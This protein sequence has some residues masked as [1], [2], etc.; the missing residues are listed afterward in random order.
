MKIKIKLSIMVIAI[1]VAV[2]AGVVVVL[3]NQA[4]GISLELSR[5]S[6]TYM[7][8]QRTEFWKG[9]LNGYLES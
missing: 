1:M 3:V 4:S 9:T 5:R 7:S 6:I 2:V 8:R